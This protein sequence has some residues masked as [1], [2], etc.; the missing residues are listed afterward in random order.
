MAARPFSARPSPASAPVMHELKRPKFTILDLKERY[1][2]KV[3]LTML[4]AY[5][6]CGARMVDNVGI[7][8]V[9]I[10][11]SLGQVML[12]R[13]GTTSVSMEEMIHH[14]RAVSAGAPSSFLIGD[15]PFGSY[16]SP[17]EGLKNAV[18]LLKQG[19]V[20]GVKLEGGAT[21]APTV[22]RM[23]DH[24]IPV[25]GHIGLTP[26]TVSQQG[27]FR[28]QGR[29]AQD[30]PRLL[31]DA[32]ALQDAGCF[33]IVIEA[34]PAQ[35]G[36]LITERLNVPTIGIGA[37]PHTSGQVL[38]YHDML[39]MYS[40]FVPKF[41]KVYADIGKS[42]E[43]AIASYRDEVISSAFPAKE[44]CYN[45]RKDELAEAKRL[46]I[47]E[48]QRTG[49]DIDNAATSAVQQG[50]G[51]GVPPPAATGSTRANMGDGSAVSPEPGVEMD[52]YTAA[53]R[54]ANLSLPA[55]SDTL[56]I[57]I[58]G[59]G[60][61]G[62]L[63]AGRIAHASAHAPEQVDCRVLLTSQWRHQISSIQRHGITLINGDGSHDPAPKKAITALHQHRLKDYLWQTGEDQRYDV[64]I[65]LVKSGQTHQAGEIAQTLL[66]PRG[67]AVS[68]Q[69]GMGH[70]P[71]LSNLLPQRVYPGLA[72]HGARLG[73]INGSV[74]HTGQGLLSIADT[75]VDGDCGS[76][77][78]SSSSGSPGPGSGG[79]DILSRLLRILQ[80]PATGLASAPVAAADYPAMAWG[81]LIANAAI[82]PI[83]AITRQPNGFL[84]EDKYSRDLMHSVIAEGLACA[85]ALEQPTL[86]FAHDQLD[87]AIEYVEGIAETTRHNQSS[88]L[89]DI[90]RGVPTE[91]EAMN[92]YIC[93]VGEERGHT[94]PVNKSLYSLVKQLES[95][96]ATHH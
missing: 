19:R 95:T 83:T 10:G 9:L 58:I 39:G 14:C 74:H 86:P 45:M 18:A 84:L 11:D 78:S 92:G 25:M 28:V 71:I 91:I 35:V 54:Q 30:V 51:P 72:T 56:R 47:A 24:G 36:R 77:S 21:M 12:G 64:A 40:D 68:F 31:R 93:R 1:G 57:A 69:N 88:M 43:R 82:N 8:L 52:A 2:D 33:S 3:P 7:D 66:Q 42:V 67:I 37:G 94:F 38:V 90:V 61:M 81:K 41:C 27:G 32:R 60:A 22:K 89:S 48:D 20:D 76:S 55:G 44:H 5:D 73:R 87:A 63:L 15:M 6:Y 13:D 16:T 79:Q 46:L 17:D 53:A 50:A 96:G 29:L 75:A 65:I 62:T 34:V 23:V 4:T 26:Q 59:G 49:A 70:L 80:H 85:R